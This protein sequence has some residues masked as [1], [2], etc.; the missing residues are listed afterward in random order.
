[1]KV[2]IIT[3]FHNRRELSARFLADWRE[4]K[5]D[6][7]RIELLWGDSA[8]TDGT[9]ELLQR[10]ASFAR[11]VCFR[12]N[13]GFAAGNNALAA[14]ATGEV[15]VFLNNDT[16]FCP[17]WLEELLAVLEA[18][19]DAVVGNIQLHVATRTLHHAGMYFAPDGIPFHFQSPLHALDRLRWLPVPAVTGCCVAL[20]RS[21]FLQLGGFDV[22]YKNGYEDV[23]LCLRARALGHEVLC[24]TRSMLW[25]QVCSSPGRHRNDDANEVRFLRQHGSEA[26]RLSAWRPPLLQGP[27]RADCTVLMAEANF[28][29]YYPSAAAY[30]EADCQHLS[31]STGCPTVLRIALS[32]AHLAQP[33]PLRLDPPAQVGRTCLSSASLSDVRT[34]RLLWA[35]DAEALSALAQVGGTAERLPGEGIQI[36]S[37]GG[38]PQLFLSLPRPTGLAEN[39]A[40]ELSLAVFITRPSLKQGQLGSSAR[41][42]V[43]ARRR[44]LI[45]LYGLLP[46]GA[47]GGLKPF[48]LELLSGL[49]QR[50]PDF[51]LTLVVRPETCAEIAARFP[52]AGILPLSASEYGAQ[53]GHPWAALFD[54]LYSP[55]QYSLLSTPGLPQV[56]FVVDLLHRDLPGMLPEAECFAREAWLASTLA[57]STV[58]QCNSSF[59]RERL[60]H[61]YGISP[62]SCFVVHNAIYG[63]LEGAQAGPAKDGTPYFIYPANDWPH[64]NHARLLAAYA[65]YRLSVSDPWDLVLSGHFTRLGREEGALGRGVRLA[66]F[67]DDQAFGSLFGG[68]SALFFPSLYEGFGIPV[69]D[70]L[71]LGIPVACSR[72]ASLPEVGE[73]ACLYFDPEKQD[74]LAAAMRRLHSEGDLR[75]K[76]HRCGPRRAADFDLRKGVDLLAAKLDS[77]RPD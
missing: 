44:V 22:S 50:R 14:D 53:Q 19:P 60:V 46:G 37:T 23:D 77:P 9:R 61:H 3:L 36:S 30:S 15:L 38:D 57:N 63:R 28:Q 27:Q 1:M 48:V 54:V 10:E 47:N 2:S 64:K 31:C 41:P 42:V 62:E 33:F 74:E 13:P 69:L 68:A 35:L 58:L 43:S 7:A 67:V 29:V 11:V 5:V 8:S 17:G 51:A 26:R 73:D 55:V 75:E 21:L 16:A 45:D 71:A 49:V 72:R 25:H 24:S 32:A 40:L 39:A 12:A 6:P 18:R 34:G 56:G 65:D 66:G 59:V 4:A 20:S 76:L 70:A 52:V